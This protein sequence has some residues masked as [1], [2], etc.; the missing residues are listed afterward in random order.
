MKGTVNMAVNSEINAMCQ[1]ILPANWCNIGL[2]PS[3]YHHYKS[4]LVNNARP[5][6]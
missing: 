1:I 6:L 2:P 4:Y 5:G 3:S